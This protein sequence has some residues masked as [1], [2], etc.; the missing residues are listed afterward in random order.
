MSS[1]QTK[2]KDSVWSMVKLGLI[3]A[4]YAVACCTVLAIINNITA[5]V[6]ALNQQKKA[7][8]GMAA[9]FEQAEEF[10]PVEAPSECDALYLAKAG[11]KVIGAVVQITG[12]TYDH[13]TIIVGMTTDGI[14]TGMQYLENTDTPGFGQKA[15]DPT[16]KLPDGQTFYGQFAGKKASDGFTAGKTFDAI[17]GA[18]I[19]SN[20]VG[21][22]MT[23]AA[24]CM[25]DALKEYK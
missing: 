19:T 17:S 15:S 22:L 1:S 16:F 20:G 10:E 18:T 21:A 12:A 14:I 9:V 4:A 7:S 25:T 11:G 2:S 5:P 13:S 23:Q 6:I 24:Q 8:S 3:L